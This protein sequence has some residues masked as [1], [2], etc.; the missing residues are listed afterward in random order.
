VLRVRGNSGRKKSRV[1]LVGSVHGR[2][3]SRF[4]ARRLS[5]RGEVEKGGLPR[6]VGNATSFRVQLRSVMGFENLYLDRHVPL[7][8]VSGIHHIKKKYSPLLVPANPCFEN[9]PRSVSTCNRRASQTAVD[10]AL[11]FPGG[12]GSQ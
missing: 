2:T 6:M 5:K 12:Q 1:K 4:L 3:S 7:S 11:L 10:W 8:R 9:L